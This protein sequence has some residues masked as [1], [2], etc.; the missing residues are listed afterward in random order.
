MLQELSLVISDLVYSFL[1]PEAQRVYMAY[2]IIFWGALAAV[3]V[4]PAALALLVLRRMTGFFGRGLLDSWR[5]FKRDYHLLFSEDGRKALRLAREL[6]RSCGRVRGLVGPA[7]GDAQENRALLSLLGKFTRKDLPEALVQAHTFIE[8]GGRRAARKLEGLLA[9]EEARWARSA[10]S[11]R[12]E[13]LQKRIATTRQRLAQTRHANESLEQLLKGL[14]EAALALRTLEMEM[15]SLGA[16]RSQALRHLRDQLGDMAE[17][18]HHQ[19]RA[20]LS[21]QDNN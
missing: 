20:H 15:A 2:P 21:M 8:T 12:R 4:M 19:R 17:G 13:E 3:L 6:R 1:G 11:A 14:D 5:Q 18:L 9:E 16:T 10:E 7:G